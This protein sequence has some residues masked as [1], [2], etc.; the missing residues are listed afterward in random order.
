MSIE[1]HSI[2][3]LLG[4]RTIVYTSKAVFVTEDANAYKFIMQVKDN[5]GYIEDISWADSATIKFAKPDT[6][7][8]IGTAT[9]TD[10]LKGLVEYDLGT[11]ETAV[12]G[13][14]LATLQLHATDVRVTTQIFKFEVIL[15]IAEENMIPSET[16][17]SVLTNLISQVQAL[18]D[19]PNV[20]SI[21]GRS[22]IVTLDKTDVGLGNVSNLAP[23]DY[24]VSI[25][26]A[27]AILANNTYID[28]RYD[29]LIGGAAAELDTLK[30]LADALGN[31]PEFAATMISLLANKVDVS[32]VTIQELRT[33]F[34]EAYSTSYKEL[35]SV[36]GLTQTIDIWSNNTK[37]LKL[38]TKVLT[39]DQNEEVSSVVTTD[40]IS[41][42]VLTRTFTVVDDD[43]L[44]VTEVIT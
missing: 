3:L 4:N 18:L 41:G 10:P 9:I 42:K 43:N 16:E 36:N 5:S 32:H 38:F 33:A 15:Q 44:Q 25:A 20:T 7:V 29:E 2:P 17:Y 35:V 19:A 26:Q 30:E 23:E 22:G 34:K 14:V 11:Q 1:I 12:A 40:L 13:T 24:P 39:Y 8:V 31:N 6:T 37:T 28:Q 21:N 27:A